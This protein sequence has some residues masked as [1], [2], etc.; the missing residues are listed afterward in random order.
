MEEIGKAEHKFQIYKD[1][2]VNNEISRLDD[3]IF[4][5]GL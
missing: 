1:S 3:S 5:K 2:N 4:V